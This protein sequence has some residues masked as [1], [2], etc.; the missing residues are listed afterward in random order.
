MKRK[1]VQKYDNGW[2]FL[3]I[4][5]SEHRIVDIHLAYVLIAEE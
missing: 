3:D 5:T 4:G 2:V 1:G